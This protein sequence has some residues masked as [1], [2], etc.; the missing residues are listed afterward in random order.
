MN[1]RNQG[2]SEKSEY[3]YK[4]RKKVR[5]ADE[6][7]KRALAD[8]MQEETNQ[9]QKKLE[10]EGQH[11]FS[12]PFIEKVQFIL[13]QGKQA[14]EQQKKKARGRRWT[15]VA[16]ACIVCVVVAGGSW[17]GLRGNLKMS[18]KE[19]SA[20]TG[21]T[22]TASQE[23]S[24]EMGKSDYADTISGNVDASDTQE[25]ESNVLNEDKKETESSQDSAGTEEDASASTGMLAQNVDIKVLEVTPTSLKVR[26][27]NNGDEDI[28]FGDDNEGIEVY[29]ETTDT[30]KEC[31]KQYE[32]ACYDI[33]HFVKSGD[34][35]NW[36][37][38]YVD[39]TNVYGSLGAGHYRLQKNISIG[40]IDG[41]DQYVQLIQI[42][43][44]VR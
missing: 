2:K 21:K 26:L 29:D 23:E 24:P 42:E 41:G 43:F 4:K 32:I 27:T 25:N 18:Q 15:R 35:Q 20:L 5:G 22:E 38:W 10:R 30:W 19:S 6:V 44:D 37:D 9:V 3:I 1:R 8:C 34:K 28:S 14:E 7:L 13:K 16:A 11:A 39:W 33:L 36:F 12:K 40:N 17:V 31:Q